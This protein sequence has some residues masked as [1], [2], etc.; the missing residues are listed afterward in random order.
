LLRDPARADALAQTGRERVRQ[1]FLLPRLLLNGL[2]TINAL[3]TGRPLMRDMTG[4]ARR[5]PVCGMALSDATTTATT[6]ESH[7]FAFCSENCRT[8]FLED[9]QHYIE[10]R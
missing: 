1:H 7:G 3:V 2:S 4:T 6:I 5:D 9:P 8:R 10:A